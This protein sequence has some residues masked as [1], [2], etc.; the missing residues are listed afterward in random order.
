MLSDT[1]RTD[2]VMCDPNRDGNDLPNLA[3]TLER[4]LTQARITNRKLNRLSQRLQKLLN[5]WESRRFT[6]QVVNSVRAQMWQQE[7]EKTKKVEAE[8][9]QAREKIRELESMQGAQCN[10]Y[11]SSH[12]S[13]VDFDSV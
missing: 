11:K 10:S 7:R 1:P 12:G 9:A 2:A 5:R 3:R 4:E 8:L 6:R 13:I